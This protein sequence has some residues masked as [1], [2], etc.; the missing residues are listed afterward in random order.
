[1]LFHPN[2]FTH[3]WRNIEIRLEIYALFYRIKTYE[4]RWRE[5]TLGKEGVRE[6]GELKLEKKRP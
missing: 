4:S 3:K 2:F 5:I 6:N 1:M